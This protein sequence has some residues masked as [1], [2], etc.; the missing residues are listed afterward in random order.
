MQRPL[1]SSCTDPRLLAQLWFEV[2][3]V[4][5]AHPVAVI[6]A[7]TY[8]LAIAN[9]AY[10]QFFGIAL[11][12]VV[13][14]P[15]FHL[16]TSP[17]ERELVIAR[18]HKLVRGELDA[19]QVVRR[20]HLLDGSVTT[21]QTYVKALRDDDR[22]V[23]Y[24]LAE[25][26]PIDEDATAESFEWML[27]LVDGSTD[28][29]VVT[30]RS[31]NIVHAAGTALRTMSLLD[32][33]SEADRVSVA[34]AI[35]RA[36]AEPTHVEIML[37]SGEQG[38]LVVI[39]PPPY[40]GVRVAVFRRPPQ[41]AEA[42]DAIGQAMRLRA[43]LRD[44]SELIMRSPDVT[45]DTPALSPR[46]ELMRR[47]SEREREVAMM[48][49]RGYRTDAIARTLFVS[50]STVRNYYSS[51][52]QKLGVAGRDG[53]RELLLADTTVDNANST[54]SSFGSGGEYR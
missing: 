7:A 4:V 54:N 14:S 33:V 11:S 32:A 42:R 15:P 29:A 34:A 25:I 23:R 9:D 10:A 3:G 49:V 17:E 20:Y 5:S 51:I 41:P 36:S 6:D 8:E 13:G 38:T 21:A 43:L 27:G 37:A 45:P 35:E 50:S 47:L 48:T 46:Q 30:D 40:C 53:L 28:D 2:T 52:Y 31:G 44:V 22:V 24:L 18:L 12:D 26:V 1:S 39:E 19:Y 16:Q